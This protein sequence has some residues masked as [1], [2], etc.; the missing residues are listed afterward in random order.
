ML[1]PVRDGNWIFGYGSLVWRPAFRYVERRPGQIRGYARRFWQAST[2]HRGTPEAPG[3]VLTL[4]EAEGELCGGM[5]YRVDDAVMADVLT[6]LDHRE[7]NG[8]QRVSTSLY[9]DRESRETA[10]ALVY[11]AGPTNPHYTG[12]EPVEDIAAIAARARGPSGENR[13]YVLEL[14]RALERYGYRDEHVEAVARVIT[15]R[16]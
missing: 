3:R 6:D 1:E 7:K 8:Y 12:P 4:V 14:A 9:F 2:D 13:E 5:G 15:N 10:V 16:G 11:I